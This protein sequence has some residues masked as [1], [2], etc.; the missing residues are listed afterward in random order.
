[1]SDWRNCLLMAGI[2]G[3]SGAATE[4]H[5]ALAQGQKETSVGY[6]E[7]AIVYPGAFRLRAKMDT[8]AETT[9]I[10]VRSYQRFRRDGRD[11]V[12]FTLRFNGREATLER[13][14]VRIARIRRTGVGLVERPVIR[15]GICIA[16][17]FKLAQVNLADRTGMTYPLLIGRRYMS[18]GR[19]AIGSHKHLVSEPRCAGV[20]KAPATTT[21]GG[22]R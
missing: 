10:H 20:P 7:K 1:M 8:G 3:V 14:V 18:S 22:S 6:I 2:L 13:P 15:L 5:P 16:G 12:R 21:L 17:Y 4:L 11:W 9:A 19:L